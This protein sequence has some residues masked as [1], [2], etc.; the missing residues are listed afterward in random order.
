MQAEER[1]YTLKG[2]VNVPCGLSLDSDGVDQLKKW[3]ENQIRLDR[4][5][6]FDAIKQ[7]NM[8]SATLFNLKMY[9]ATNK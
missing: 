8:I 6:Q 5:R 4:L 2:E 9:R 1:I 3:Y 7:K